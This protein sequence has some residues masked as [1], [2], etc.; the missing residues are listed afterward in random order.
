MHRHLGHDR[1]IQRQ[2]VHPGHQQRRESS[3]EALQVHMDGRVPR[4]AWHDYLRGRRGPRGL[5]RQPLHF[6]CE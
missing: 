5:L 2:H 3:L 4:G 1:R 6:E